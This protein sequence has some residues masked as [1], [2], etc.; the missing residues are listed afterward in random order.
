MNDYVDIRVLPDPDFSDSLMMNDLFSRLHKA[1]VAF[2]QGEVGVSFPKV[3]ITLGDYLRLHGHNSSLQRLMAT[4]WIG[5]LEDYVVVS[6]ITSIPKSVSYRVVKRV[7]AKSSSE[8]LKRRS[9]KKGWLTQEEADLKI[10]ENTEKTLSLPYLKIRSH[11]TGQPFR[12]FIEHCPIVNT[13]VP[14]AF[15]AYGLSSTATIPWF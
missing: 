11:S 8:R 12:L 15:S 4:H 14:G 2:G 9:V 3:N 5:R 1:L 13:H 7:Q 6:A 10:S